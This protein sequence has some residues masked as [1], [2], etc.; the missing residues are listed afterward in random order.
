MAEQE[1]AWK[2]W[3]VVAE[4]RGSGHL[5]R[6]L[7][8]LTVPIPLYTVATAD[9]PGTRYRLVG[10]LRGPVPTFPGAKPR[11][12]NLWAQGQDTV[13]WVGTCDR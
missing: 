12:G 13:V 7:L 2:G 10:R 1:K 3:L 6:V 5:K 8:W 4:T 9:L 11:P